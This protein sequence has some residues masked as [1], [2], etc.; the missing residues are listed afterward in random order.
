MDVLTRLRESGR[1]VGLISHV[2][3]LRRRIPAGIEV[4]KDEARGTATV[5]Q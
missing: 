2:D 4:L 3:E 5:K 1:T